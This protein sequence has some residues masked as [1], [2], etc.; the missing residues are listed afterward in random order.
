MNTNIKISLDTRRQKKDSS[1]PIILRL[2]HFRKTTSISLGHS[3]QKEFWDDKNEKIK[4][5]FKGTNSVSKL[6][7]QFLKE[8]ARAVDIIDALNEKEELDHLSIVQ[9]KSKIVKI[10]SYES[11]FVYGKMLVDE[12]KAADRFGN[13]NTYYAVIKVLEK[14]TNGNDLKFNEINYDFLNKFERWHYSRGNSVNSLSTYMRTIKAI[15]NVAIRSDVLSKDAY[16][17]TNYKI[18][19]APTEKRALDINSLKS[20]MLLDLEES[21]NLFHYRNYFLASYMLY[22]IS[23]MDLAFLTT[24]NIIDNRIKF[25]RK[26]TAKP[27][28]IGITEQLGK[29]LSFYL[30]DKS[31][32]DFI[33]PIIKRDTFELQYK[34]VLWARKRYNKG[35]KQIAIKCKINQRLSS[36]VSR[37]SFATQAM[38]QDVPLQAISAMLGHNRLSTTQIYLKTLPNEILDNYNRNLVDIQL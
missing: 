29:I 22:G 3:V 17:F 38:L 30:K 12:M 14:F 4:R 25:Q 19:T 7:N 8:K 11:F 28:D 10:T 2:T 31:S 36:Y 24:E 6:N 34:D 21:D 37:H 15:I 35:L 1:Y 20:I 13:A 9:L 27:Y 18:R 23:Y 5:A 32:T 33:F 26:K 16:P